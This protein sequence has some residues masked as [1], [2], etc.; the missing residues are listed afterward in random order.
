MIYTFSVLRRTPTGPQAIGYVTLD[1]GP[2]MLTSFVDCD[3]DALAI[4]QRVQVVFTPT[5]GAPIVN[6]TPAA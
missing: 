5:E 2:S 1:E 4:G 6:F 3:V